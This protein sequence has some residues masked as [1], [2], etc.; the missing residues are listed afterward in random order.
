MPEL[1][2]QI[3]GADVVPFAATP[4]LGFRL[5]ITNAI[6]GEAIHSVLVQAQVRIEPSRRR[7]S[8]AEEQRLIELFGPRDRWD[9][10]QKSMLWTHTAVTVPSFREMVNVELPVPC[11]Y[12][13]NVA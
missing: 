9:K 5:K 7:Y 13:F 6:A 4:M 2:F 11:T 3:E 1:R 10:T 12:D 8:D